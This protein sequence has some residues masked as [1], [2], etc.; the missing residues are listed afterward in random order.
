MFTASWNG[1]ELA[2]SADV[3]EVEGRLYFPSADVSHRHLAPAPDRSICEWKG[4]EADYFDVVVAGQVNRAAAWRYQQLGAHA[5]AII[6]RI[7]FWKDVAVGWTGAGAAPRPARIEARTPNV[8]KAL[9]ATDVVWQP[10]LA[11][12]LPLAPGEV[13]AGYLIPSLR[14]I[15]D[16][17]ATPPDPERPA[18]IAEAGMRGEA[19]TA[20]NTAHPEA[21]YGYIAVWG[22]ATP[23]ADK[24]Q[25][26]RRHGVVLAL[27]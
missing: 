14:V 22:S 26:L 4:G 19:V 21:T 16:V 27:S 18:R 1:T 20:W 5:S 25:A 13:F 7:A 23:D 15:V 17:M 2:R 10:A 8:A 3:I 9:G 12:V 11:G 24:I 6:G